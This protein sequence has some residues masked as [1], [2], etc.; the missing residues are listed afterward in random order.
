MCFGETDA[1][2]PFQHLL[3]CN[4]IHPLEC[5]VC[6]HRINGSFSVLLCVPVFPLYSVFVS[7]TEPVYTVFMPIFAVAN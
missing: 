1:L 2:T 5:F 4:S 7:L 3:E 6:I